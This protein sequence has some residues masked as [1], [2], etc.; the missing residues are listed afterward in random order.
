MQ[1]AKTGESAHANAQTPLGLRC[2][3]MRQIPNLTCSGWL[4]LPDS[5]CQSM[6]N[7]YYLT[8][9]QTKG[10]NKI[11]ACSIR[12]FNSSI[13]CLDGLYYIL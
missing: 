9:V 12:T 11:I 7:L 8:S 3:T 2:P 10:L 5:N 6:N 4:F 13:Q 1:T